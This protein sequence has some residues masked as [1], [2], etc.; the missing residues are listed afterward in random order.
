MAASVALLVG[1]GG[2]VGIDRFTRSTSPVDVKKGTP[3]KV[4][5]PKVPTP[6]VEE[7]QKLREEVKSLVAAATGLAAGQSVLPDAEFLALSDVAAKKQVS[8]WIKDYDKIEKTLD[9]IAEPESKNTSKMELL[10]L[11]AWAQLARGTEAAKVLDDLKEIDGL[12]PDHKNAVVQLIAH[13]VAEELGSDDRL[14][15]AFEEKAETPAVIIE[16]RLALARLRGARAAR[17]L[18]SG[19]GDEAKKAWARAADATQEAF[20]IP[21]PPTG[22]K[23]AEILLEKGR[24]LERAGR[25]DDA[26][27][28][29]AKA[30]PLAGNDAAIL[31]RLYTAKARA[32]SAKMDAENPKVGLK[33]TAPRPMGLRLWLVMN[34]VGALPADELMDDIE[35]GLEAAKKANIPAPELHA[36]KGHLLLGQKKDEEA[37]KELETARERVQEPQG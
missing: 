14:S 30:V 13:R 8:D 27:E 19:K 2:G 34:L 1:L 31:T 7:I 4:P 22:T 3:P 21:T 12:D 11:R 33:T 36:R 26:L 20:K 5:T 6:I 32:R 15:D 17:L 18:A 23:A 29:Y 10:A 24:Y 25:F 35:K 16:R 28:E 9:Q 37:R